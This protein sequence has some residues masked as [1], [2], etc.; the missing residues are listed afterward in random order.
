[1]S[2]GADSNPSKTP[3]IHSP[4]IPLTTASS[5]KS[6]DAEPRVPLNS[7]HNDSYQAMV[8]GAEWDSPEALQ[9]AGSARA[10]PGR[11]AS[12]A[13]S[14]DSLSRAPAKSCSSIA[15]SVQS[16]SGALGNVML[17]IDI[18]SAEP[19]LDVH[20]TADN[21]YSAQRG[22]VYSSPQPEMSLPMDGYQKS[23]LDLA[24][25]VIGLADSSQFG[26]RS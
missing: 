19:Q 2:P 16:S 5:R 10:E 25:Q 23:K 9:E 7:A 8:G 17:D 20:I 3:D 21:P 15:E 26:E 4:S 14:V 1:M 22:S 6:Q 24:Q 11:L 18:L 13:R 12:F